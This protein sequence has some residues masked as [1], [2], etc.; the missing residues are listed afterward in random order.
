VADMWIAPIPRCP[1]HGQM[2]PLPGQ[3]ET[4]VCH[5][6]DGEGCDYQAPPP[7]W[8]RVG[9]TTDLQ[10]KFTV[11]RDILDKAEDSR[12]HPERLIPLGGEDL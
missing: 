10:F 2:S 7:Q 9:Y 1:V 12:R 6:W 4:W 5:G 11:T 3:V 8:E